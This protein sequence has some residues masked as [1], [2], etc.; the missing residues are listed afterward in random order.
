MQTLTKHRLR[1]IIKY[2]PLQGTFE[3]RAGCEGIVDLFWSQRQ[4]KILRTGYDKAKL[5]WLYVH[6]V[7]PDTNLLRVDKDFNNYKLDNLRLRDIQAVVNT[8]KPSRRN[9]EGYK[10]VM[11]MSDA[12]CAVVYE[13]GKRRVLGKFRTAEQA[14]VCYND[15]KE[16]M[17]LPRF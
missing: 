3:P 13:S 17:R 14:A 12:F 1:Q 7:Y 11:W 5:A 16:R 4:I 6:G 15:Y 2:S 8:P 10:G 9:A